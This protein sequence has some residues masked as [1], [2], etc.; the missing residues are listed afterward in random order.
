LCAASTGGSWKLETNDTSRWPLGRAWRGRIAFAAASAVFVVARALPFARARVGLVLDSF[1]YINLAHTKSPLAALA[2]KRPPTFLLVMKM[3]SGRWQFVT[4]AQFTIAVAAWILL[5]AVA[6]RAARSTVGKVVTVAVVLLV[7]SCLDVIQ[8]DRL[9]S[10][11]SLTISLGVLLV[12]ASFWLYERVV[13]VRCAIVGV[14]ALLWGM[15]RDA[16]A[17]VV[18]VVGVGLA[19]SMLAR[20]SRVRARILAVAGACLVT[21]GLS[22]VSGA[23]GARWEQPIQ[24]VVTMRLLRS[25][26]RRDFLL[27]RGLPFSPTQARRTAGHCVNPVGAFYCRRVTDPAFYRWIDHDARDVYFQSWFAF[28]ATTLWEPI[29]NAR[30]TVGTEIPVSLVSGTGFTDPTGRSIENWM[31]PR[32][33]R[34]IIGWLA[35]DALALAFTVRRRGW[36]RSATVPVVLVLLTYPHLWAVWTGDAFDVTR[37][38]LAASVQLRLGLWL[39]TVALVDAWMPAA[40]AEAGPLPSPVPEVPNNPRS[41]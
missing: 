19:I 5:A 33:P 37:H 30:L 32:S 3:L 36:P 18:G 31:F 27:A 1:D 28:P 40:A 15:L 39:T 4:W 29:A 23:I 34:V 38:A 13:P 35:L 2:A 22:F 25:P 17:V 21:L 7:G 41:R 10:T 24:N 6:A 12:A 20:R 14:L 9:I 16:N 8:W 11:E 26:E